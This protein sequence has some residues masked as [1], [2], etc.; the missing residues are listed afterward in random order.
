[1]KTSLSV[2]VALVLVFGGFLLWRAATTGQPPLPT[3]ASEAVVEVAQPDE[4]PLHVDDFM[5][6]VDSYDGSVSVAGVVSAVSSED[7]LLALIDMR[8]FEECGTTTCASLSLPVRWSGEMPTLANAVQVEGEA[9]WVGE[10]LV[11]VADQ[12]RQHAAG[13][14]Q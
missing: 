3:P 4:T 2:A 7:G 1:M 11:F 9:E 14:L 13:S 5:K 6:N 12:L 8:E 10:K